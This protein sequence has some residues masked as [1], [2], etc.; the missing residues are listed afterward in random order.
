MAR[1]V[2]I[3]LALLLS[4]AQ[5]AAATGD[6]TLGRWIGQAFFES[7][8]FTHCAMHADYVSRWKLLFSINRTGD[9]NVGFASEYVNMYPWQSASLWLQLD[10][11]P[12]LIRDFK[13]IKP[14]L[15]VAVFPR[16]SNWIKKL[17]RAK[18]LK[19]NVGKRVPNFDLA[20]FDVAMTALV[21]CVARYSK[22]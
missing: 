9:V 6:F 13:P 19:V 2:W 21:A 22:A 11:D 17:R 1:R 8:R 15:L 7:D 18:R 12:V 20:G 4:G 3:G 10:N 5:P 14:Q 16:E